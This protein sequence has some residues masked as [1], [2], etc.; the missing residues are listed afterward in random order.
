MKYFLFLASL[1]LL[2]TASHAN[3]RECYTPDEAR[4]EQ[5]IRIHSELMVVGLNCQHRANLTDA[6]Q[7]Y[8]RFTNQHA[9]LLEQQDGVMEAFYASNGTAKPSRAVHNFRTSIVNK[10]ASDAAVRP[11]GFCTTYGS[12]LNFARGL[13]TQQ[14]MKWASSYPISKPLCGQ[15]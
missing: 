5:L 8:K 15:Y 12:R 4:A 13:N 11:D 14:L 2:L 6:Y 7:E 10:I 1:A 3:A 9:Y